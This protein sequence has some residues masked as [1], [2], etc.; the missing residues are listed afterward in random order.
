M[1]LLAGVLGFS[2]G[3]L[4]GI[5]C[6][7]VG[8]QFHKIRTPRQ[9]NKAAE[10][11]KKEHEGPHKHDVPETTQIVNGMR[12]SSMD[13]KCIAQGVTMLGWAWLMQTN[14]NNYFLIQ[15][16]LGVQGLTP[17]TQEQA[18]AFHTSCDVREVPFE[19]AFPNVKIQD[20]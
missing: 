2:T 16:M 9:I 5:F 15:T 17:L 12:Y 4:F 19:K 1:Q 11:A 8:Y 20:A 7:A 10:L 18:I 6:F 14:N 3:L 13:S